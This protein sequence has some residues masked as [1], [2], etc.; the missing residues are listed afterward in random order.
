MPVVAAAEPL[1]SS[2]QPALLTF[3]DRGAAVPFTT[4]TLLPVRVRASQHGLETLLPG[5]A[6][7]R[8]TFVFGWA[9]LPEMVRMTVHDRMLH[10]EIERGRILTPTGI[11]DA[12]HLVACSGLAGPRVAAAARERAREHEDLIL[13]TQFA[14]IT[15]TIEQLSPARTRIA[16]QELSDQ[17]GQQRAKGLLGE[18]AG[19][20][21][22]TGE[23]LYARLE[24]WGAAVARV[25]M[26]GVPT[27]API[28]RLSK[29]LIELSGNMVNWAIRGE[30]EAIAEAR[31]IGEVAGA[32]NEMLRVR[33]GKLDLAATKVADV[34]GTWDARIAEIE[35]HV[36]RIDWLIDGWDRI[37]Q[38]WT[39]AAPEPLWRQNEAIDTIVRILP[40]VPEREL[41]EVDR[42]RWSAYA[43]ISGAAFQKADPGGG[44]GFDLEGVLR[45]EQ[46]K[47]RSI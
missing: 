24:R 33:T 13:L 25:G 37:V 44:R 1:P 34:L 15:K 43:A 40:I 18:I 7:T 31:T 26:T 21:G 28:R 29:R 27:E 5:M 2:R 30:G 23:T 36:E 17:R 3:E 47:V 4:P 20:Y 32:T 16:L 6:E 19:R 11:R 14:L 42:V 9:A 35:R 45:L 12:A 41:E 10:R 46:H 39:D 22:I 8:A 38:L